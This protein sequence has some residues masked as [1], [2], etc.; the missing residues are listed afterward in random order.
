MMLPTVAIMVDD[1]ARLE[2]EV[3]RQEVLRKEMP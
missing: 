3:Y 1:S 2:P